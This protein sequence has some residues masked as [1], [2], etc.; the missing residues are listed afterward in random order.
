MPAKLIICC[1]GNPNINGH[2]R[3]NFLWNEEFK[4]FAYEN[5][6]MSERE[7]NAQAEAVFKKN[8]DLRP[9]ARVVQFSDETQT[10]STV[11]HTTDPTPVQARPISL[12][13][14]LEVVNS[15]APDRLK[16][17]PGR[18]PAAMEV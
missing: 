13:E 4:C 2:K 11:V 3:R 14:A 1:T 6:V 9:T 17:T 7:F 5:R 12:E 8:W 18:K 15:L 10:V 16:K